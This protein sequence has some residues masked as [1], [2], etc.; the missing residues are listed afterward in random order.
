MAMHL[1]AVHAAASDSAKN[2]V[3]TTCL[4]G[5]YTS[6]LEPLDKCLSGALEEL[7]KRRQQ[8]GRSM[9]HKVKSLD[10]KLDSLL[11]LLFLMG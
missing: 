8:L 7:F 2:D 6:A 5:H 11:L 4:A 3:I 1:I 10:S 9:T